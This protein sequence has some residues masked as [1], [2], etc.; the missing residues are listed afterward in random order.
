MWLFDEFLANDVRTNVYNTATNAKVKKA[1]KNNVD[2]ED[3]FLTKEE[4]S[5]KRFLAYK[6]GRRSRK[7]SALKLES[8]EESQRII[9][10]FKNTP[11]P[12]TTPNE[13]DNLYLNTYLKDIWW[14]RY[15]W[16]RPKWK[17]AYWNVHPK[18]WFNITCPIKLIPSRGL[19]MRYDYWMGVQL[20]VAEFLKWR[21]D[22]IKRKFN[23][24]DIKLIDW[25]NNGVAEYYAKG[26][27]KT[28]KKER[29]SIYW[30]KGTSVMLQAVNQIYREGHY[31]PT[32]WLHWVG[33]SYLI[34]DVV[35][36]WFWHCDYV[37]NFWNPDYM[38]HR[39][40]LHS[41]MCAVR[42]PNLKEELV[43]KIPIFYL[44]QPIIVR[45]P[46]NKIEHTILERN[47]RKTLGLTN[48]WEWDYYWTS[49]LPT[50]DF[51]TWQQIKEKFKIEDETPW[52][53]KPYHFKKEYNQQ[54]LPKS[55]AN[56]YL[57]NE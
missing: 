46:T 45:V 2:D 39:E 14:E 11:S 38:Q 20:L 52:D 32:A 33:T 36:D 28:I 40:F 48:N 50:K 43:Q 4:I 10:E 34:G 44:R 7:R 42:N 1:K 13:W 27:A 23:L 56:F 29:Q 5:Y 19:K 16:E 31:S 8:D 18:T 54:P 37:S 3:R 30:W 6:R 9:E 49:T 22:E 55:K 41:M 24:K 57:R 15:V 53:V 51:P 35:F 12:I 25:Y 47:E 21:E 17:T 26:W